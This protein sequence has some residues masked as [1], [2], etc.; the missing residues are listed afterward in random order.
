[1]MKRPLPKRALLG[2][3]PEAARALLGKL[4]VHESSEGTVVGRIVETEAYD[5]T[6]LAS[7]SCRGR[8]KRNQV[9]FAQ[10][11]VWYVYRSYGLHWCLNVVVGPEDFGA[12][13]LLRAVEP[14]SGQDLMRARRGA[15]Q[16]RDLARGPGRLCQA[17]GVDARCY[18]ASALKSPLFLAGPARSSRPRVI[19]TP[20]IGISMAK[21][22]LWRFCVADSPYVSR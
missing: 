3:A 4:L 1:M 14:L 11:G 13:V 10:G 9:M 20:R 2:T 16:D 6:D 21:E 18:G 15:I 12:A 5:E 8:T 7:H 17:F 19:T 22:T